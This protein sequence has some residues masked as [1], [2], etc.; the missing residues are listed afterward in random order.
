MKK[1]HLVCNAHLDPVWL[2]EWQEAAAEAI[3]TF[4][5]AADL[6]EEYDAFAFNHN[7]VLVYKWVE[8]Y[9]PA[10][11][12][13]IQ[14]LVARGK[15]HIMGGWYLQ[16]DCNMPSGESFVRQILL[17][18]KYF[19]EKFGVAPTTAINFDPF[20]HTRGLVQILKKSGYDSYLFCRPNQEDCTLP[21]ED[22][23]WVGYDGSEL[24]GHRSL[25]FYNSP[26][27]K[28]HEKVKKWLEDNRDRQVGL[29]LWGVGNHG[30]GPSWEDL[31]RLTKL[32]EEV[33]DVEI[34]HSTPEAYFQEIR[35]SSLPRHEKDLNSWAVGCYTSQVR[36]KQKHRQLENELYMLEKMASHASL[37]NGLEYP[38]KEIKEAFHDLM[39]AE[40][41]DILPGTSI[42]PAEES[43]LRLMDHGLEIASRLK[44]KA[45]FTLAGGQPK[46]KEGEIPILVYNPHPF[47]VKGIFECEFQ[48]ADQNW[49][50]EFSLPVVYQNGQL[51]PSQAEKE[52]S[53]L[54][55]DWRKRTV[56][57]AELEPFQMNRFDCR[58]QM[59]PEKP[60][61]QLQEEDGKIRF[62]TEELEVEV[63]CST[64]LMDTYKVKGLS[65]LKE[66]AFKALIIE[67][68][69][70]SW[71]MTVQSFPN[72]TGAFRLMTPEESSEFAGVREKQ[73][74]AVRVIEDGEVRTVVEALF[75]YG[76]S[77]LCVHYK[78]PKQGTEVEVVVRA[79]WNEKSKML[80][81]SLPTPFPN[82]KYMGQVVYGVAELPKRGKE[83]VAQKWVGVVDEEADIALTC[84][85][86]GVYGSSFADGELR[87]TLLRS[88]AYSGHPILDRPVLPQDRY[89]PRIDQGERLFRFWINGG[90]AG[91]RLEAID[92]EALVHN[93]KPFVLSFF[94]SG[95]GLLPR[96]MMMVEDRAVQLTAFK[97]AEDSEDYII[98]LFEPT[99]QGRS[100][101]LTFPT[102][103]MEAEI[104][105]EKFEI[106]TLKLDPKAR[107]LT[108]VSLMEE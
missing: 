45:F 77:A 22:F 9:E 101:R 97:K 75:A 99:G 42:Q 95:D 88:P 31:E 35:Q 108:E 76:K 44:A 60:K 73:L 12:K 7:E 41:H 82:S 79:H 100:T 26:R 94:P 69:E 70:D 38:R 1:L 104:S 6:C 43:S 25:S 39:M 28:A 54:N 59:L 10:L 32:M 93:E 80:K 83:A 33:K 63:N 2:W 92:R 51:I 62:R 8:E 23:I 17:G 4:R 30:G 84:I 19:L 68:N 27:G 36:I 56:F 21:S 74:K 14:E 20:G 85:N 71:G 40:F 5:V 53:N 3:S 18:R 91:Q 98:R 55:L 90:N 49:K 16:P 58:I 103:D 29:L 64:G 89:S 61:P 81:L 34:I 52:L 50:D 65:Y 37:E 106:K 57:M 72:V 86:D 66:N 15:W 13:R 24:I 46:A 47:K 87:L 107:T 105:L 96:P 102:L 67:D 11:F 48:L 78:L